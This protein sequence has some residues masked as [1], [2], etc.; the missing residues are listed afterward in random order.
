MTQWREKF[1]NHEDSDIHIGPWWDWA[2]R[3]IVVESVVLMVWW[4]W[5]ARGEDAVQTWTL[6]SSYN[7]G[8]VLIQWAVVLA[9]LLLANRWMVGRLR[10]D[11][12]PD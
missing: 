7:I 3:L 8:S 4:L 2:I 5:S 6:I 12:A 1:I 10:M 11:S 9:V